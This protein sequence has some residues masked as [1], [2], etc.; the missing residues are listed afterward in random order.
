MRLLFA[1]ILIACNSAAGLGQTAEFSIKKALH[2][3]PEAKQG[4][5]L[6]H[7]FEFANTGTAPLLITDFHVDCPC[8]K[9]ILPD[10]PVQPN[11]KGQIKIT[12]DTTG[13][14]YYQDRII[15]LTANTK[16]GKEKLRFKVF[17]KPQE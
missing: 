15:Y 14:S 11:A 12:F 4:I 1:I 9:V 2:K 8:T 3:F 10:K 7:T 17:V 16:K 6:E 13:K 5:T